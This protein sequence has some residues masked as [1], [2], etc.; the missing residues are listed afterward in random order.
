MIVVIFKRTVT[1]IHA[2]ERF[3]PLYSS[4]QGLIQF[5]ED[6]GGEDSGIISPGNEWKAKSVLPIIIRL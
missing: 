1:M 2:D 3:N 6:G 5:N 4:L